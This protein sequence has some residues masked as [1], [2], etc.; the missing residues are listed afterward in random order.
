MQTNLVIEKKRKYYSFEPTPI[1]QARTEDWVRKECVER[2]A[3]VPGAG[4]GPEECG[5]NE[6]TFFITPQ[7][8]IRIG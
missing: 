8:R 2:G 3:G 6:K 5:D 7:K 1:Y 4:R